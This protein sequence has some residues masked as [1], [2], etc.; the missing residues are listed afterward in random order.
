MSLPPLVRWQY[1]WQPQPGSEEEQLYSR[2]LIA[3]DWLADPL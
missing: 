2:Y 3:K 1:D